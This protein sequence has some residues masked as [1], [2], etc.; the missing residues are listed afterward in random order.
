MRAVASQAFGNALQKSVFQDKPRQIVQ[1]A[2]GDL[3]IVGIVETL[4]LNAPF[5][6][7]FWES[8]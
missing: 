2:L 3:H 5:F 6:T 7:M 1:N 8:V 4:V